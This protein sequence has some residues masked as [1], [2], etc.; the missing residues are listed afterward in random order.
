M[1]MVM[2]MV[3]VMILRAVTISYFYFCNSIVCWTLT[4]FSTMLSFVYI[5]LFIHGSDGKESARNAGD[6]GLILGSGRS[7]EEA[8]DDPLHILSWKKIP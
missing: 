8:S 5:K 1:K 4:V 2:M 7:P 6:L 3:V